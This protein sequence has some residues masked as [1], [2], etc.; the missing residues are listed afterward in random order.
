MVHVRESLRCEARSVVHLVDGEG[1]GRHL[2]GQRETGDA[3]EHFEIGGVR[4]LLVTPVVHAVVDQHGPEADA[5]PW[6]AGGG[7]GQRFERPHEPA[8]GQ[9]RRTVWTRKRGSGSE[10]RA[11]ERLV[12]EH[13][14][15]R[16]VGTGKHLAPHGVV[17]APWAPPVGVARLVHPADLGLDL[18][19]ESDG[20]VA[21]RADVER[22]VVVGGDEGGGRRE[23]AED[24][25]ASAPRRRVTFLRLPA[26]FQRP[27]V[28]GRRGA[29]PLG[30][31]A[32]HAGAAETV[33]DDVA[34]LRVMEDGRDYC[35][36]RHLGVVP[37]CPVE[38]VG[39]AG[40][41]VNGEGLAV[42]RL[43]GVVRPAVVLNELG[44]EGVGARGVVRR[45][46]QPQDV[47]VFGH[48]E[49]GPLPKLGELLFQPC[50]EV[51]PARLLRLEAHPQALHR[52]RVLRRGGFAEQ[53]GVGVTLRRHVHPPSP[54]R[55]EW[56]EV[57]LRHRSGCTAGSRPA[58]SRGSSW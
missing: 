34:R 14:L 20:R 2:G 5:L 30:G 31:D 8:L 22:G 38:R 21:E 42:I 49:V 45:V 27:A 24:H 46:G 41:D 18:C 16:A 58:A 1:V 43:V 50:Q 48:G 37:V 39:L 17:D 12:Q 52:R 7:L 54:W 51:L 10:G 56:P 35:Q 32:G 33:Q 11:V 53:P 23:V 55:C 26:L 36:V 9:R 40:A 15:A 4:L 3:V 6:P 29:A 57:Q 28:G 25:A 19:E 47:L 44:Q 13:D